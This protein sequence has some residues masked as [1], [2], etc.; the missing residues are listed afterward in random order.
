VAGE[1]VATGW[2]T[3]TKAAAKKK[4]P[5]KGP[6]FDCLDQRLQC[7]STFQLCGVFAELERSIIQERVKAGL[8][9]ARDVAEPDTRLL[10]AL[11]LTVH[12]AMRATHCYMRGPLL[13]L[14]DRRNRVQI[15]T[16]YSNG[17]RVIKGAIFGV[18]MPVA[19]S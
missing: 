3:A 6:S 10:T 5:A 4:G 8:E 17:S 7:G 14:L 11:N 1:R 13:Q 12:R 16:G 18:P 9:R 2:A 19:R 15:A